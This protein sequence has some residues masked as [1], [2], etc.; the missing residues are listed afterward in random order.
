M[1]LRIGNKI[2]SHS[3]E[4]ILHNLRAEC[5]GEFLKDIYDKK[6]NILVTCPFHSDGKEKS[7]ACFVLAV[8]DK[9]DAEY[10]TYHCFA[11]GAKGPL[12]KL[13]AKCLGNEKDEKLGKQWLLDNYGDIFVDEELALTDIDLGSTKYKYNYLDESVL[14]TLDY[15]NQEALDYLINKRHLKPEV[16]NYFKLGYNKD[17]GSITFPCWDTHNR[18]VGIFE[19]NIK[20]KRFR[21]PEINPKPIYLLNEV[22]KQGYTKVAVCESQINALTLW[23]YGIPAI[24]LF[25]TGASSQYEVLNKCGIRQFILYFD[26]DDAGRNGRSKFLK[27]I[28]KTS[29][30]AYATLPEGKDVNDLTRDEFFSLQLKTF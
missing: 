7:P 17:T 20:T 16:V 18:L 15:N 10:G 28:N 2:I 26:G 8:D 22:I 24:A 4:S 6:E 12:W 29:L 30:V 23:G 3:I 13:V 21:I 5:E 14:D 11:C 25:G 27:N 1:K 9:L 19:R